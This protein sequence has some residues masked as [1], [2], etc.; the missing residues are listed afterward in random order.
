MS[1]V[2]TKDRLIAAAE[3]LFAERGIDAVSLREI[4]RAAG[5]RN[6]VALQ[7]HFGDRAGLLQALM[8]KHNRDVDARRHALLDRFAATDMLE[9]RG[10]AEALVLPLA[11]KL[12]DQNGGNAY[13]CIYADMINRRQPALLPEE[14]QA[15]GE[16]ILRWRELVD[17]FLDDTATRLHRRFRVIR[18]TVNE[19][20]RRAA[21]APH[22]DDRLFISELVDLVAAILNAPTSPRTQQLSDERS[23]A[24][25]SGR[26]N[27]TS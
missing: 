11:S 6:V 23:R 8:D 2:E 12:A 25:E 27:E 17:P 3:E 22:A 10:L 5:V 20:A 14:S 7:Y 13:L 16:S 24:S 21:S 9:I 1:W 26:R 18:F 15:F 19:L 4:Q